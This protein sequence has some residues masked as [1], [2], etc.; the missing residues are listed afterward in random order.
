MS[1]AAVAAPA[2]LVLGETTSAV[3]ATRAPLAD[4]AGHVAGL[5]INPDAKRLRRRGAER[6]TSVHPD[7]WA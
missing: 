1:P 2:A 6:L 7:L 3:A 5:V 4:Y